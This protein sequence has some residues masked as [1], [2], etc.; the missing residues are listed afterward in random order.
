MTSSRIVENPAIA[1]IAATA[2]YFGERMKNL[3]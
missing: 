2:L 3:R 1:I